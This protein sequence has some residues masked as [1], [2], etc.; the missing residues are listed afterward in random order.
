VRFEIRARVRR[1]G[2]FVLE[3]DLAGEASALAVVGPSG[4]G[5][6]TLLEAVAGIEPGARVVLDGDDL[7]GLPLHRRR[8]GYVTQDALLFPHLT[9]RQNLLYSPHARDLG[10]VPKALGIEH[11]LDRRPRHLSGGERRRVALA[12]AI[13]SRP[14]VLLLDEP[15]AGLDEPR[16]REAM[17]LLDRLRRRY[18]LP[19]ILVSHQA[20]ETIG[21][22]DWA[23][24]LEDGR[25]VA[26]G[27]TP[28]VLRASEHRIDNYLAG[29]VTGPARVRV[30]S[31]ELAAALPEGASGAV[32]LA[33]Y[34]HDVLLSA[35]PLPVGLSARNVFEARVA[36]VAPAG[37]AVLVG[38]AD[39]PLRALV[40]TEAAAALGLRP[41]APVGVVLKATSLAYLGPDR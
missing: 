13:L 21:L 28:S 24:R 3:A 41:G 30:G 15:F 22:T 8:L 18:E 37:E 10:D 23:V 17:A 25:P 19:L 11:L 7:S 40:T 34:A 16:R 9:V 12:R 31:V 38:L 14:R 39:P 29:T 26:C 32:R 1:P 4:S 6:S 27:P 33:C 2:G 20:D 5:K 35:L 36:S